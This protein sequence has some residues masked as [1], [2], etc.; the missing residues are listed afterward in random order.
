MQKSF[1]LQ[2]T[3]SKKKQFHQS[4]SLAFLFRLLSRASSAVSGFK[5]QLY[6]WRCHW[7]KA[8]VQ[9][10]ML[11]FWTGKSLPFQLQEKNASKRDII[12]VFG[13]HDVSCFHGKAIICISNVIARFLSL[14]RYCNFLFLLREAK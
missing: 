11:P 5:R 10:C 8:Q 1:V 9:C 6:Q 3:T 12:S 14:K 13:Q 4:C 7:E 2:D